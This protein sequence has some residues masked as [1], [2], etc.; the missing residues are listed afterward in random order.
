[1]HALRKLLVWLIWKGTVLSTFPILLVY[2]KQNLPASATKPQKV[3][4][5]KESPTL[6]EPL[7]TPFGEMNIPE[8]EMLTLRMSENHTDTR[9]VLAK[10]SM[11][12]ERIMKV[13][14]YNTSNDKRYST[15]KTNLP[16]KL[17]FRCNLHFLVFFAEGHCIC[18][19]YLARGLKPKL[20]KVLTL[21]VESTCCTK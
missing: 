14:T 10:L 4:L 15:Y 13:V 17:H 20:L 1:M 3:Q 19:R 2:I 16:L 12:F 5:I 6:P 9:I 18:W 11:H 21:W 8:P 7:V